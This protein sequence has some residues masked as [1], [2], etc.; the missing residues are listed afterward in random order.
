MLDRDGKKNKKVK[1]EKPLTPVGKKPKSVDQARENK[2]GKLPKNE[3]HDYLN[4]VERDERLDAEMKT[5]QAPEIIASA[6]IVMLENENIFPA[7][8]EVLKERYPQR[9]ALI[10]TFLEEA[11]S[12]MG[13]HRNLPADLANSADVERDEILIGY[14]KKL[15]TS[16]SDVCRGN[17]LAL[18]EQKLRMFNA[19]TYKR[20]ELVEQVMDAFDLT[21]KERKEIYGDEDSPPVT[22]MN[23]MA[24]MAMR[25]R[26][27]EYGLEELAPGLNMAYEFLREAGNMTIGKCQEK[28]KTEEKS[29][30]S[31][32]EYSEALRDMN[33]LHEEMQKTLGLARETL[34]RG[35]MHV[36]VA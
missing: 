21:E 29:K 2:F 13:D 10:V 4:Y 3:M 34:A 20:P 27:V 8:K 12:I 30:G 16:L 19:V 33:L 6:Q 14:R 31:I 18:Y 25:S 1:K 26:F 23:M 15:N 24:E 36:N 17:E 28:K 9:I 32:P 5:E 35:Q 22:A 7:K 11:V